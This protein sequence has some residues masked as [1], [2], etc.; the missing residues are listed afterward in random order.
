LNY[1]SRRS[2]L[3]AD[4]ASV[5]YAGE[6]LSMTNALLR[7]TGGPEHLTGAINIEEYAKQAKHY[8]DLRENSLW[9]KLLQGV[10]ILNRNHPFS[11]VRINELIK[12]TNSKDFQRLRAA[13]QEYNNMQKCPSCGRYNEKN[14]KFCRYCGKPLNRG[15]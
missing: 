5:V 6:H 9:H 7:L 3:S 8:D 13:M 11:A 1:W 10:A 14:N 15:V 2:E 4:R 12:W